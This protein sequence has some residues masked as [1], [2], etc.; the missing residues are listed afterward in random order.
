MTGSLGA[1][2][3]ALAIGHA[4]SNA[5]RTLPAIAADVL[6]ADLGVGIDTLASIVATFHFA[7]ACAQVP[8]GVALDRY[9]V[10]PVALVS[11]AVAAIGAGLAAMATGPWSMVLAQVI[12]GIGCAGG[13]VMPMTL[14]GKQLPPERFGLWAALI[15]ALG[16]V[17]MLVSASPLAW[18]V[19]V[20]GWRAG[21][22]TGVVWALVLLPAFALLVREAPPSPDPRRTPMSD[23]RDVLTLLFSHKLRAPVVI[24]L[25]SF[26]AI[27]S[28]RGLWGG[29]W[30]M[31]VKGLS[32]VAAGNVLLLLTFALV[33]GPALGG[34]AERRTGNPR[35]LL[36]WGHIGAGL[37]LFALVAA[38][39][40]PV[41]V[42]MAL[43]IAFGLL[44]GAQP[45]A[46]SMAR[47]RVRSEE[48]GRALSAVNLAF[49]AGA[50]VMQP[51]SGVAAGQGGPGAGIVVIGASLL[52]AGTTFLM[53]TRGSRT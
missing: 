51:L 36:G 38:A 3:V 37:V 15:L 8:V 34:V 7:F 41:G 19:E 50:S 27:I 23:A 24:A 52:I 9:G 20:L 45:L 31:E 2:L 25:A 53:L 35:A 22:E 4:L 21:F 30:L 39:A 46:F 18:L 1:A 44:I 47:A 42:D 48:T 10:R 14:A 32:R 29:P 16:N 26:A 33:A 49:F 5:L 13:L 28:I 11:F 6:A 43:F 40:A 17:G 12:M